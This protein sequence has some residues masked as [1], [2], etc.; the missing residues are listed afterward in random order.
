M[1]QSKLL[2]GFLMLGLVISSVSCTSDAP[3]PEASARSY[4]QSQNLAAGS[5]FKGPR[6]TLGD[7][8][9]RSWILL[10]QDGFPMEIGVELTPDAMEGLS[11]DDHESIVLPLHHKAKEVTPFDHI[12]LNWNPN[13]HPPEG[14]FDAP[15]FDVHFYM[16][17]LA[18]RLA[19][20]DWSPETDAQFSNYPPEGY[21]PASYFTP[22]G[23]GTSEAQ[24]GKH[25]IPVN[26]G[27]FLPFSKILI[28]GT[29]DG[30]FNFVE[31]M[32]TR[33]YL[34]SGANFSEDYP[35]PLYV[36]EPD[37]Y[38]SKYNIYHNTSNGN[39]YISLSNFNAM[40]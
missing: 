35:Q 20:P 31:P 6:V 10:N 36:A 37:N 9:A 12:G 7:G 38:P 21:M 1:K 2:G 17:S 24:M 26:L 25:W 27:D 32:V 15:H 40:E 18:D 14:V 39:I 23:A 11:T 5:L 3:D 13:G 28:L 29:Y 33:D 8:K 4:N 16:M 30:A 19:I 22:P 34:M